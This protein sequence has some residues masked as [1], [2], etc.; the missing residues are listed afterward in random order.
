M[1]YPLP[2]VGLAA[3]ALSASGSAATPSPPPPTS[4]LIRVSV[5]GGRTALVARPVDEV[6]GSTDGLRIAFTN[7]DGLWV[8]NGDS[9]SNR[10]VLSD[11]DR[12][13]HLAWSGDGRRLA[14]QGCAD[15]PTSTC[16][17]RVSVVD[18]R[19]STM[20]TLPFAAASP[21]LSPTGERIAVVVHP[22]GPTVIATIAGRVLVRLGRLED[23]RFAPR[24]H[25]LAFV[26]PSGR[27]C[28]MRDDGK[29]RRCLARGARPVWSPRATALAF[30]ASRNAGFEWRFAVVNVFG[31]PRVR[32][33]SP[34]FQF[35]FDMTG[36]NRS[37]GLSWSPSGRRLA[38][39]HGLLH[40][41][42]GTTLEPFGT[43]VCGARDTAFTASEEILYASVCSSG[44]S[45]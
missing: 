2:L 4:E 31:S 30:L 1:H 28:V 19:T 3:L 36:L 41:V 14:A 22:R 13:G 21:S 15:E 23:V 39:G 25:L 12:V 44:P 7:T 27:A 18:V 43:G 32:A 29:Q 5:D 34:W 35:P 24:G 9:A 10:R 16:V 38:F 37:A 8:T 17:P 45:S 26:S 40:V 33:V 11:H 42:P 20:A 6:A